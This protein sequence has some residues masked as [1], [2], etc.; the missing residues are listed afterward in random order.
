MNLNNQEP[1]HQFS[2]SVISTTSASTI[3]EQKKTETNIYDY[4]PFGS[5]NL[6][7]NGLAILNRRASTH[8]SIIK[9]KVYYTLGRGFVTEGNQELTDYI[10]QVN[11]N[12]ENLRKVLKKLYTDFY[13]F[14]NAYM[15]VVKDEKGSF[16]HFYH[17]DAT[18]VRI[19]K[20]GKNVIMHPDW[21][22]YHSHK[23]YAKELPLY[24]NFKKVDGAMR[25]VFH[26]KQYEAQ[27][28]FYGVPDWI[29]ALDTAAIG[30]KTNRWNL[31]R[32][33]N[34]FQVSGIMEV[35]GDMTP[36]DAKK[37]KED[38]KSSFSGEDN[39]GKLLTITKKYGD[40]G[41]GTKFTPLIQNTDGEWIDL[42]K[43]SDSELV[44]AHNWFRSLSGISDPVGFDTKRIRNEYQVAKNTVISDTQDLFLDDIKNII[45]VHSS[46]DADEL[47]TRNES[48]VSLIDLIDVNSCMT[49]GEARERVI[50]LPKL[51]DEEKASKLI[52]EIREEAMDRGDQ[53]E[54]SEQ[55]KDGDNN[56]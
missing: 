2:S 41:E 36:E 28:N 39:V 12:G 40:S 4:I 30:Y 20:D 24:P 14:G 29:A 11:N 10:K 31:S 54:Q 53:A 44:T 25:S 7:I 48:P 15:E 17:K 1:T 22:R 37:L 49:V 13:S 27:F 51:E 33:E 9:N 6:F 18:N 56:N 26:F 46:M 35:V 16:L 32:L 52:S 3:R 55:K 43:Q 45:E 34:S 19:A 50:G 21:T 23:K 8:R 47:S 38:M 42:H 5:D